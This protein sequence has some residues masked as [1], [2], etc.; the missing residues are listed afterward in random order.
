MGRTSGIPTQTLNG[1]I[2]SIAR[3][4]LEEAA[5]EDRDLRGHQVIADYPALPRIA[6]LTERNGALW[7]TDFEEGLLVAVERSSAQEVA[8]FQLEGNPTGLVLGCHLVLVLRLLRAADLR[9]ACS[10]R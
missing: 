9:G 1:S 2:S 6:G 5:I 7:F 8:R 4:V 3:R 10:L